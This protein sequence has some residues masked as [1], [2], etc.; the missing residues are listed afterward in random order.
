M[1]HGHYKGVWVILLK[2]SWVKQELAW[3]KKSMF[4]N[5]DVFLKLWCLKDV[6]VPFFFVGGGGDNYYTL[7]ILAYVEN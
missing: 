2:Q 4:G 3:V 5:G 6:K 7:H 1:C